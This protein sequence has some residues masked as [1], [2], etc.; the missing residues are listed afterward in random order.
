MAHAARRFALRIIDV[1][2]MLTAINTQRLLSTIDITYLKAEHLGHAQA[3]DHCENNNKAGAVDVD[4][5]SI[6]I[7]PRTS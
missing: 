5:D 6:G 7:A 3:R 4:D 2:A 1:S